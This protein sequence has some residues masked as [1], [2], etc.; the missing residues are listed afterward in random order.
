MFT[1]NLCCVAALTLG[2][3]AFVLPS[4]S[5]AESP[6]VVFIL[7][8]D[9]GYGDVKC[10]GGDRCQIATPAFDRLAREG[11]RFTD[12][13]ANA[14]VCVPTRVAIMTGRYP[15][16]FAPAARGG[17]WGFLGPRFPTDQQTLGKLMRGAGYQTAYVGKWH[18]GTTM[19]TTDDRPQG[20]TNVDYTKPLHVGPP[21]YGFDH[22]FILPGSLDMFPYAFARNN[23]WVG[24]VTAQKGW[25]AFN[26]VG[27]AAEDFEDTK[28]LDTF[29]TEAER[30]IARMAETSKTPSPFFL[31]LALTSPHTPVCP[32]EEFQG[33]SKL[34]IYGDFVME[35]DHCISRVLAA[36]DQ[37]SVADNTLVIATSDHG[38]APYAGRI[39]KAT[40]LQLKELEQAGHHSAG[41]YRGYKF[42]AYEGGLRVPFVARWPG[43]TPEGTTCDRLIGLPDLMATLA[44]ITGVELAPSAAVDSVSILPLLKDPSG[45][46]VRESMILESTRA[47]VVRAGKW[48]LLLC[49]GSGC[50]GNFGNTPKQQDAWRDA[51]QAYGKKPKSHEELLQAPFVQLFDLSADPGET[52]NLAKARPEVVRELAGILQQNIDNGRSTPGQPQSNGNQNIQLM[53]GVPPV[54]WK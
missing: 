53:S 25:S 4:P 8:D 6:N 36:L 11:M 40:F 12:A 30:F 51:L 33:K 28:V 31:Y 14:S 21:Q 39:A 49:P 24:Q 44:E 1:R 54:V 13:H 45:D 38:P 50:P 34:G 5:A 27:P 18:L 47:R 42:S 17:P 7:C 43:E 9:L 37:H 46:P 52:N 19:H 48:K 29:C 32:S 26:R 3:N 22:S 41:P 2:L 16:R 20:P 15:W 10:F 23:Q 35:T